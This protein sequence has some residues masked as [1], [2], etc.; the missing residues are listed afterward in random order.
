MNKKHN[1][2]K[3]MKKKEENDD[4]DHVK[5]CQMDKDIV[6]QMRAKTNQKTT[7]DKMD[8]L[9]Q[10]EQQKFNEKIKCIT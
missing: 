8:K 6:E 3:I 2:L 9:C 1:V 10:F 7:I 4:E 5:C